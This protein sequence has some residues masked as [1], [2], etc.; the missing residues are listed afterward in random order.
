MRF[1]IL[2]CLLFSFCL[3]GCA[4]SRKGMAD[5]KTQQLEM[6]IRQLETDVQQKEKKIYELEDKLGQPNA[7]SNKAAYVKFYPEKKVTAARQ[8][9]DVSEITPKKVQSALKKTGFYNGPID[10]KIGEKTKKALK[11]FQKANGLEIDGVVGKKTW[12]RL[13]KYLD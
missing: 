6:R 10:G 13:Q 7:G 9:A 1:K 12:I 8:E 4:A 11:E 5:I 2:F 3:V